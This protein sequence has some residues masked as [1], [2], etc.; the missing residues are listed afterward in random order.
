LPI[1]AKTLG[2][3]LRSK[4]DV[5]E[6]TTILNSKIWNL[7]NDNILPAL[8]KYMFPSTLKSLCFND[9]SALE[10]LSADVLPSSLKR[11]SIWRCPLLEAR[12]ENKEYW[13]NIAHIPVTDINGKLTM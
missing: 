5:K 3:L 11:L 7:P 13:S 9:C 4:L 2:G 10:S 1:A 8:S 6:W 12:Y